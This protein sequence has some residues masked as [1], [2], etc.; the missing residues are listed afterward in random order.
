MSG[1]R[2]LPEVAEDIAEAANWY[3]EKGY[4]GLGE[5]F[6]DTFFSYIPHI[7]ESGKI[8]RLVYSDFRKVAYLFNTLDASYGEDASEKD[9]RRRALSNLHCKF[10]EVWRSKRWRFTKLAEIRSGAIRVVELLPIG[11][12]SSDLIRGGSASILSKELPTRTHRRRTRP[13]GLGGTSWQM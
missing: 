1:F 13:P 2:I 5:R 3:D 6:I 12:R 7:V 11:A 4:P 10:R 8:H 9:R